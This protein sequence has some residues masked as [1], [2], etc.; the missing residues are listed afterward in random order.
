V[1][2]EKN[3]TQLHGG[4]LSLLQ[5][6]TTSAIMNSHGSSMRGVAL[7]VRNCSSISCP[8]AGYKYVYMCLPYPKLREKIY[9]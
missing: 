8:L 3:G 1:H 2:H 6:I 9:L 5:G 4:H 7:N